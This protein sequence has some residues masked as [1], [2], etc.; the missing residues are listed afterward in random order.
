MNVGPKQERTAFVSFETLAC[1]ISGPELALASPLASKTT[2]RTSDNSS[3]EAVATRT[4]R[5]AEA[6]NGAE[7][8]A[9]ATAQKIAS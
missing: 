1:L 3:P 7:Y 5:S 6:Q 9:Y 2:S 4:C 8:E